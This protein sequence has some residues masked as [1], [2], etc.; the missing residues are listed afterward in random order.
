MLG[1]PPQMWSEYEAL[2][3]AKQLIPSSIR[4]ETPQKGEKDGGYEPFIYADG[5]IIILTIGLGV[6]YIG[7]EV[8]APNYNGPRC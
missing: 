8:R 4:K 3:F 7:V 6:K 2:E 1:S 5:T